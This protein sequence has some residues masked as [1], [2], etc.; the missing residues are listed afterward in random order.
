MKDKTKTKFKKKKHDESWNRGVNY[1]GRRFLMKALKVL[2][3]NGRGHI[4][5]IS[6]F[7]QQKS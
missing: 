6:G 4:S 5:D 1:A 2:L 3:S 7:H